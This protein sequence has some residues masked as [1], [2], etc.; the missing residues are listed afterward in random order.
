MAIKWDGYNTYFDALS[1]LYGRAYL[2]HVNFGEGQSPFVNDDVP[3]VVFAI[4][5]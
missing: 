3:Y 4:G 2:V 5:W 1:F